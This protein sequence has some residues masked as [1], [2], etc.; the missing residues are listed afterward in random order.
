MNFI[1]DLFD[2]KT[3]EEAHLQFQKFSRGEF[4]DRALIKVKKV[5]DKIT[6][7][8]TSEFANEFVRILAEKVKNEKTK[9]SGAVI[10]T[11]EL[12]KEMK[13]D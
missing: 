1:K 6:I 5:K 11:L 10:S 13:F 9:V 3:T 2:K 12:D 8:T 4:K 7:S